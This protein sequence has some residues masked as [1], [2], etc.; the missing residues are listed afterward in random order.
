LKKKKERASRKAQAQVS[1]HC[2]LALSAVVNVFHYSSGSI[3]EEENGMQLH[4]F[5][6]KIESSDM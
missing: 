6:C 4:S 3:K 1:S 2:D 5:H